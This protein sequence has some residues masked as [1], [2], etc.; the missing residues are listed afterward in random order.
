VQLLHQVIADHI[1]ASPGIRLE[2]KRQGDG[3]VY[4]LDGRTPQ[5]DG[6]VPPE[7]II[8]AVAVHGGSVVPGSYQH[9]PNHRL[10]TADGWFVLPPDIE[11]ALQDELRARCA[12]NE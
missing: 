11:I 9:N 12:R 3:Y 7:D 4:L 10:L 1:A 2:G 6:Q 5:P 8:G